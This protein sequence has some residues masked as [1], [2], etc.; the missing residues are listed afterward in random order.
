MT[1]FNQFCTNIHKLC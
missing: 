1:Y